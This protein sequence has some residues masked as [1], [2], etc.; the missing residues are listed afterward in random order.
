M[1]RMLKNFSGRSNSNPFVTLNLFQDKAPSSH[2]ILKQ[3]QDDDVGVKWSKFSRW[4]SQA[5][6]PCPPVRR[7]PVQG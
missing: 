5:Q 3:V 2:V 6:W 4:L 1:Q 7:P